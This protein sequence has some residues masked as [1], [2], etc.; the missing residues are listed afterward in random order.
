MFNCLMLE[1]KAH[2]K[3]I[4]KLQNRVS[5]LEKEI[6]NL[7]KLQKQIDADLAIPEKFTELSQKDG[8]FAEYEKNQQKL[9]EL[10]A[11]WEKAAVQLEA[12]K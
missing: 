12:I 4:K 6:E 3:K 11:E 7:D 5:K 1:Q 8:F 2:K 10:E 9:Q